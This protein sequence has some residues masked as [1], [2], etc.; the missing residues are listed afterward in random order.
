MRLHHV[1]IA[2]PPGR[3][4]EA[5]AFY[6]DTVGFEELPRP[7]A[8]AERGGVWFRRTEGGVPTA[9]LHLGVVEDF[10]PAQ[11]AHPTLSVTSVAALEALAERIAATGREVSW[12]GRTELPRY[13]R[14]HASDPFGNR[15][16]VLAPTD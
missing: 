2:M 5:R 4:E 15:L 12:A 3:E 16:A 6:A 11:H 8:L 13:E 9:E 14:F 10:V 7:A 1:R